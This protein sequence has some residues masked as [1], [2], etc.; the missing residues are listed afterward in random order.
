VTERAVFDLVAN[1]SA[2]ASAFSTSCL[3]LI[4]MLTLIAE[5]AGVALAVQLT[6]DVN[7]LL[8]IPLVG[9]AVWW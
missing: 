8:W 9:F 5:V 6:V 7:Y 3:V 1:G 4:T 2:R